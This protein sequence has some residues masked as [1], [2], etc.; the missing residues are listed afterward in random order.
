MSKSLISALALSMALAAPAFAQSEISINHGSFEKG[1]L[2]FDQTRV[3]A[4]GYHGDVFYKA[5]GEF[6]EIFDRDVQDYTVR[7]AWAPLG[8]DTFRVGPALGYQNFNTDDISVDAWS[9]GVG[10]SLRTGAHD[11]RATLLADTDETDYLDF[12]LD[13]DTRLSPKFTLLQTYSH[14]DGVFFDTQ[15][16][17][18]GARYDMTDRAFVQGRVLTEDSVGS[19]GRAIDAGLGFKF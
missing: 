14:S 4:K 17:S 9:A 12:N 11:V 18:V 5:T 16:Y 8:N 1:D 7:A 10:A 2:D 15:T 6:A 19:S 13:W 3:E